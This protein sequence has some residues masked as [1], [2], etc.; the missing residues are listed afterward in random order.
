[1]EAELEP[2]TAA[3]RYREEIRE[4]FGIPEGA[5]P[6]FDVIHQGMG[7]DGHTA[8]LFPGGRR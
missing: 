6:E 2:A 3:A 1:M 8:S 4:V 7:P 5:I